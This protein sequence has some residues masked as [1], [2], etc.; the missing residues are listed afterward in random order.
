MNS[1][2]SQADLPQEVH[3]VLSLLDQNQIVY[4]LRSFEQPAHHA[5]EAADLLDCPL[6]AVVKSLVFQKVSKGGILLVLVSGEN[7]VDMDV[8]RALVGESVRPAHLA[9][10]EKKTGYPVGAV[11][12]FGM[13]G[14]FPVFVDEDLMGHDVVW[15]SAG[16]VN[17]LLGIAPEDLKHLSGG[18]IERLKE[19]S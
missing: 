12:P 11:P 17:I 6:G 14:E 8:L 9:D 16:A 1:S 4:Q 18:L 5:G 13:A 2:S 3:Q 10:V 15:S 19:I 7:R